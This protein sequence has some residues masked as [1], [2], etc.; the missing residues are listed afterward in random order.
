[1][2]DGLHRTVPL[3][4]PWRAVLKHLPRE[5]QQ[6]LAAEAVTRA[7]SAE[8]KADL[9]PSWSESFKKS[10]LKAAGDLFGGDDISITLDHFESNATTRRERQLCEI[11]R[12]LHARDKTTAGLFDKSMVALCEQM[13]DASIEHVAAK[14]RA[15]HGDDEA[16][17][18]LRRLRRL[19]E[20]CTFT[21][22]PTKQRRPEAT[23]SGLDLLDEPVALRV[24]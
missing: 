23:G 14:V 6:H 20:S 1:M 5:Y 18:V 9:T 2:R 11:A 24:P 21:Q 7:L 12:G 19:A 22:V 13:K 17:Q 3:P 10:L 16:L 8:T 4:R 15:R